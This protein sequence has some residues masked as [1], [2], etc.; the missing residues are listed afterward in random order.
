ME[1]CD[2][3]TGRARV[4]GDAL[5]GSRSREVFGPVQDLLAGILGNHTSGRMKPGSVRA[6][7]R[8]VVLRCSLAGGGGVVP[9]SRC[10]GDPGRWSWVSTAAFA[11]EHKECTFQPLVI[12]L[13]ALIDCLVFCFVFLEPKEFPRC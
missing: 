3:P 5:A 11:K 13:F 1:D 7:C 9:S 6:F 8:A 4:G 12:F 2:T 10:W